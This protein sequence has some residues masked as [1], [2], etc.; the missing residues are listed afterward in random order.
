M[1][2]ITLSL[3]IA[4][5]VSFVATAQNHTNLSTSPNENSTIQT[6][7]MAQKIGLNEREY[8]TLRKLNQER[9]TQSA[10]VENMYS[11]DPEM[12]EMKLREI[13]EHFDARLQAVLNPKQQL[14]YAGYKKSVDATAT[15]AGAKEDDQSAEDKIQERK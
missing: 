6:R 7:E 12:R 14:A 15:I 11:N 5:S 10:E 2:N 13:N 3:A 4:L 8:I 9:M 1:K